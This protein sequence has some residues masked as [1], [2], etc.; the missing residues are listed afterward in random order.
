MA[1]CMNPGDSSPRMKI[2]SLGLGARA[3]RAHRIE[4]QWF[5]GETPRSQEVIFIADPGD[6]EGHREDNRSATG[7]SRWLYRVGPPAK[8]GA[9]LTVLPLCPLRPLRLCGDL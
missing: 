9:T 1:A 6:K 4:W 2:L 5:A 7:L 3:S 8:A